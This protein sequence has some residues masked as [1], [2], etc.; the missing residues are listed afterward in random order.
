M[1][2]KQR[3]QARLR[4]QKQRDILRRDSVTSGERDIPSVTFKDSVEYVPA[5]YVE[6]LSRTYQ[7]LPERT[8]FLKLSDGQVLDRLNQPEPNRHSHLMNI[9]N[10]SSYNFRSVTRLT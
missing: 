1:D 7:N 8:R 3:E 4:K 6:G 10:E 2:D 9:C 5:S